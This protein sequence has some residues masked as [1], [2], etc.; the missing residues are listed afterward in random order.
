MYLWNGVVHASDIQRM[1]EVSTGRACMKRVIEEV[2][3]RHIKAIHNLASTDIRVGGEMAISF[4]ANPGFW[5]VVLETFSKK[6]LKKAE[7]DRTE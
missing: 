5:T 2:V 3:A 1:L 4:D 6:K 7:V